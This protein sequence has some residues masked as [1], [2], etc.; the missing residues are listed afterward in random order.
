MIYHIA[1]RSDW[2]T[3][4]PQDA[5]AP[6]SLSSEGFIHCSTRQQILPVANRFYRG[7]GHLV[8]LCIDETKLKAAL[9]WEAPAHPHPQAAPSALDAA[10]FPHIYGPLNRSAIRAV[11]PFTETPNGFTLP[12]DLP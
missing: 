6:P 3:A 9:V 4:Q 10:R 2:Q 1:P 12:A 5:Y 7:A 8:I 11:R